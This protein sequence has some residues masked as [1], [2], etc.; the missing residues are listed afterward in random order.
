MDFTLCCPFSWLPIWLWSVVMDP[1]FIHCHIPHA[2]ILFHD[3]RIEN[4]AFAASWAMRKRRILDKLKNKWASGSNKNISYRCES[5]WRDWM[6]VLELRARM[7]CAQIANR[8]TCKRDCTP[9]SCEASRER[10]RGA[11]LLF[12]PCLSR[13]R[14]WLLPLLLILLAP[15]SLPTCFIRIRREIVSVGIP[16]CNLST[17]HACLCN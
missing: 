4:L 11:L 15:S 1:C 9:Y 13:T 8:G 16:V 3:T 7:Q 12:F 5:D 2:K 17:L 6:N 10:W 14:E